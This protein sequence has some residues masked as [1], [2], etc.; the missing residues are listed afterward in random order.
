MN[1]L[2]ISSYY[3][4]DKTRFGGSKRLYLLAKELKNHADV[5]VICLDACKETGDEG[6]LKGPRVVSHPDFDRFLYI[7]WTDTR[8]LIGRILSS[9]IIIEKLLESNSGILGS[10]L[11]TRKYDAAFLA[12]PLGLSF[13]GTVIKPGSFPV[14][15][16]EDDLFLE[17]IASEKRKGF[18]GPV[19]RHLR[20]KQLL[21]FYRR[22][23]ALCDSMVAISAQEKAVL[24][25]YFPATPVELIGYGIDCAQYPFI[26]SVPEHFTIGFIGNF[27]HTPNIDALRMCLTDVFPSV[28]RA[29]PGARLAVAGHAIPGDLRQEFGR[30]NAI[31][32]L[33]EVADL[34]EF[35]GAISVFVNPI[36]S[37]RGMRTKLVEA[38]AFGRPVVSTGLGAEGMDGLLLCLAENGDGFAAHCR[39]FFSDRAYYTSTVRKNR[40]V[41]ER[42]Y[43]IASIGKRLF[44]ILSSK[45]GAR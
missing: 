7:P 20:L 23:I 28:K 44:D 1:I 29:I 25:R 32:W 37:A 38:A 13:I 24:Q 5:S 17:K 30:D 21:A 43:S 41:I 4:F 36:V 27:L 18:L 11:G 9:G 16:S 34:A 19:Y 2:F 15:Y 26:T 8:S 33:G 45:T 35:Y 6:N 12:Y 14:V 39:R 22:K 42:N 3:L 31:D 40:D 10:F